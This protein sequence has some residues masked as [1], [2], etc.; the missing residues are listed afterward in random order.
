V[1]STDDLTSKYQSIEVIWDVGLQ[2]L[3]SKMK[4]EKSLNVSYH[5]L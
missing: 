3:N 2:F 1:I 4:M 5:C